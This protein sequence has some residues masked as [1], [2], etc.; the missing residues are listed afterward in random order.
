MNGEASILLASGL[1]SLTAHG[2]SCLGRRKKQKKLYKTKLSALII[3]KKC[4]KSTLK[5]K[6]QSVKSNLHIVDMNEVVEG[7][8]ELEYLESGKDYVDNL[9]KKHPKK[10]FLLLINSKDEAKHFGVDDDSTFVVAPSIKL[11][12]SIKAKCKEQYPELVHQ[13]EQ[14]RLK[15]IRDTD[16]D[17]LNVFETFTELEDVIKREYKLQSNF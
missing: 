1:I 6:L 16:S 10:N 8:D 2:I 3:S 13:V 9:I 15:L 11:F 4:G 14:E 5:E 17:R 7:K 12:N